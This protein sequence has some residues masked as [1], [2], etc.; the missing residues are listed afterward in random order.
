MRV[1]VIGANGQL[2]TDLVEVFGEEAIPLTRKDLDVT[3]FESLKILKELKP[4]VIINT[5]AY[6]RVDDAELYPEEAFK[7]NAIGAL[8]VARI[9]NEIGAINVYIS[10]DYVF[11]GAKGEPY[12]EEDIPNPINVYGASKYIGEIFTR[13]YSKKYYIIRVA[14]L[15]GKAG[16]RGKGGNFVEWVIKKANKGEELRIV[17]D[18]FMSPTYTK[19]VARTLRELLR[20]RPSFG[21]YHMVNEG[22]CSWYE[23]TRA[24]FEILGWDVRVKPINSSEL[25]RLAKRPKFSALKNEK[26]EKIG[27]KMKHWKEALGEYLKEKG[28]L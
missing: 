9:A 12:T 15:Y 2:G 11:D 10:T 16:A 19:D 21:V 7:V 4:E 22:Y 27:L 17:N 5:A 8:N 23:F 18:Q 13:N 26:L 25:K 6:V 28:Y 3:D 24:I 14:S 1:A 20:L